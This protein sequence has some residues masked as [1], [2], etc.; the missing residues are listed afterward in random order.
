M[1][2]RTIVVLAAAGML[3]AGCAAT[4]STQA[5]TAVPDPSVV[6]SAP[7]ATATPAIAPSAAPTPTPVPPTDGRG[8]EVTVGHLANGTLEQNYTTTKVSDVTQ[9]RGGIVVGSQVMNDPRVT[10]QA[11]FEFSIDFLT[12]AG[13]EWG[14]WT[15]S[16]DEGSWVGPCTGGTWAQADGFVWGCW[17]QGTGAHA[18]YTFYQSVTKEVG[19]STPYVHGV[20]YE[21][22]PPRG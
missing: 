20:I 9:Y 22:S 5:P 12:N 3:V 2:G 19:Q 16:N 13:L 17:L 7:P 11:R 10:G 8:D 1:N 14:T 21:G 15:I 6:V 18:G 4:A